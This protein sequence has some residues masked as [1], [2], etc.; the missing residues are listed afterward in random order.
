MRTIA[1]LLSFMFCSFYYAYTQGLIVSYEE[2]SSVQLPPNRD[3]IDNPQV[4]AAMESSMKNKN[5]E[6]SKSAKLLVKNGISVY[7]TEIFEQT[8]T[9]EEIAAGNV[10]RNVTMLFNTIAPHLIYKNHLDDIMLY[11]VSIDGKEYLVEGPLMEME[12]KIGKERK[13]ISGYD[14]IEATSK[15]S[16]G[17]PITA[18]YTPDISVSAGPSYYWGL[19][20]LILY[21]DVN[22]GRRVFSCT[23]I[24][25]DTNLLAIEAPDT[26]EKISREQYR[27]M[28]TERVQ[29]MLQE[30]A[31]TEERTDNSVR[32]TG[33]YVIK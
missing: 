7:K 32:R 30:G 20:G 4:R 27:R 13:S 3:Y 21:V 19:P 24:Q 10:S 6:Q 16:D 15:T 8:A 2:T 29:K 11:Q 18:W 14:C 23:S 17:S 31:P 25:P 12:W 28:M 9:R 1:L 22:N 5:M 26:G 33:S